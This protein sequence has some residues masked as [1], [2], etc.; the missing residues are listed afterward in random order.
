MERLTSLSKLKSSAGVKF[1]SPAVMPG[2]HC[3]MRIASV[4][5]SDI[6]GLST[7]LVGM[8]ECTIHSRLFSPFP[9]GDSGELRWLYVLDGNEVVF[10]CRKGVIEALKE[11]DAAGAR[12]IMV[13]ATCI[14]E[15]IGEDIEA[16]IYEVEPEIKAKVTSVMLGQFKNVSYP[17]GTW[18]TMASLCNLMDKKKMNRK[19]VNVLGRDPKEAHTPMPHLIQWL[20]NQGITLRHLAKGADLEAFLNAPDACMNLVISPYMAPLASEMKKKFNMPYWSLH[21]AYNPNTIRTL[22]DEI[23]EQL[24]LPYFPDLEGLYG[25]V[26]EVESKLRLLL[27]GKTFIMGPRIDLT[28]PQTQY[29]TSL[30]MKPLLIHLEE[31]YPEDSIVKDALLDLDIDPYI[32]RMVNEEVDIETIKSINPDICFGNFHKSYMPLVVID[33][34]FDFYGQIGYERTLSLLNHIQKEYHRKDE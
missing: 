8:P 14:P 30:G 12:A 1:L 17:P 20:S 3:P 19:V 16:I 9:E 27:D 28:M 15:L 6:S 34:M 26:I 5:T 10:G 31:Y 22:Y 13:I 4:I 32:C 23:C 11:M 21:V 7:L 29:Y 2:T 33:N 18:K 24:E 25:E